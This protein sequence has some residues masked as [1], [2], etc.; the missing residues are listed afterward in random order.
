[1]QFQRSNNHADLNKLWAIRNWQSLSKQNSVPRGWPKEQGCC[2]TSNSL[3]NS[4][5]GISVQTL[6]ENVWN[7]ESKWQ[8]SLKSDID[9]SGPGIWKVTSGKS[10]LSTRWGPT[11]RLLRTLCYEYC[12]QRH[13]WS[14]HDFVRALFQA[15]SSFDKSRK[16]SELAKRISTDKFKWS[17]SESGPSAKCP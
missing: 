9:H 8:I 11:N 12:Q 7:L 15:K 13:K 6:T 10:R 1:M 16:T 17:K 3:D 4:Y 2:N 14:S 5:A